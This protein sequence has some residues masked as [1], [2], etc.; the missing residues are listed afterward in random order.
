M[1]SAA[2]VGW[3]VGRLLGLLVGLGDVQGL[4][5]LPGLEGPGVSVLVDGPPP[6]PGL[7]VPGFPVLAI[8]GQAERPATP[9]GLLVGLP[10]AR[11]LHLGG[12]TARGLVVLGVVIMGE[13]K[14]VVVAVAAGLLLVVVVSLSLLVGVVAEGFQHPPHNLST[15]EAL[16]C[17]LRFIV[18]HAPLGSGSKS[19]CC[20]DAVVWVHPCA[21]ISA[22]CTDLAPDGSS[23]QGLEQ[24]RFC[25]AH[26]RNLIAIQAVLAM[27]CNLVA[28]SVLG[29][30]LGL[31]RLS[32]AAV[33][34]LVG[35]VVRFVVLGGNGGGFCL[36]A[37]SGVLPRAIKADREL[38]LSASPLLARGPA[39]PAIKLGG[40]C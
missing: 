21:A 28:V 13:D 26:A 9:V 7:E 12:L 29:E 34:P 35:P 3:V 31:F 19:G 11:S 2:P 16:E 22:S 5:T 38:R 14:P 15:C 8:R 30:R 33:R 4:T 40:S 17:C 36:R 24:R 20:R 25:G 37:L 18:G 39:D 6:W 23:R 10:A 27:A 32:V 1:R